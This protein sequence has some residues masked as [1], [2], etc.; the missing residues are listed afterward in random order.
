MKSSLAA[1]WARKDIFP[2]FGFFFF[3]F[4]FFLG[5][6][7]GVY[8]V[9][10]RGTPASLYLLPSRENDLSH[11]RMDKGDII[12]LIFVT[13]HLSSQVRRNKGLFFSPYFL[14]YAVSPAQVSVFPGI[15]GG[16]GAD[17]NRS[18][19]TQQQGSNK[20]NKESKGEKN[21]SRKQ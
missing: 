4:F 16:E 5:T 21:N 13:T 3:F 12:S 18:L 1:S 19:R 10:F 17:V 7:P 8:D 14:T 2:R 15:K 11:W 6:P 20:E 9:F